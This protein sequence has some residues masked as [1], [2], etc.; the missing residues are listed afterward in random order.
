MSQVKK[1]LPVPDSETRVYW[2]GLKNEKLL[3]QKCRNC[4]NYRFYPRLVCP[5][6]MSDSYDWVDTKGEGKV[7]SYTIV[8]RAG[9]AF[10]EDVPY[11]VAIVELNEGVRMMSNI[12][13]IEPDK[14]TIGLPVRVSFDKVNDDITLPKFMPL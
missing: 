6:C 14:V 1:P 12:I 13:G 8:H 11:V 2:E 3:L 4:G 7:Y 9:G 10:K 5:E